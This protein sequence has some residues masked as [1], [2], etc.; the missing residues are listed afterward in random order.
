MRHHPFREG[1]KVKCLE[2][3]AALNPQRMEV[4]TDAGWTGE[5][6]ICYGGKVIVRFD[7]HEEP[8]LIDPYHLA[9]QT[10]G[11]AR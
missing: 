3:A 2:T 9:F 11:I 8:L 4:F 1:D 5:I 7:Q 6:E 10:R